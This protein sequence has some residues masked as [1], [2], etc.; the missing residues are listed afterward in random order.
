MVVLTTFSTSSAPSHW[1]H[2]IVVLKTKY[3]HL[4]H[5][6]SSSIQSGASTTPAISPKQERNLSIACQGCQAYSQRGKGHV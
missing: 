4:M 5:L 1:V 2:P 3:L 6:Q